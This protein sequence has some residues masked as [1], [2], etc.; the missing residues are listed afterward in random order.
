VS[1][2]IISRYR[3][4]SCWWRMARKTNA[5]SENGMKTTAREMAG[6]SAKTAAACGSISS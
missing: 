1:V 5:A 3:K 4:T 2:G 6:I